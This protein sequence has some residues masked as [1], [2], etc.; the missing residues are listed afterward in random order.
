MLIKIEWSEVKTSATGKEYKKVSFKDA[1]GNIVDASA[2]SD[3]PF[4]AQIAPGA[5]IEA[6]VRKSAD[7]KYTNLV[8]ANQGSTGGNRGAGL[9]AMKTAQ[10]EK[11]MDKKASQIHAAQDRSAWMWAKNNAAT[12]IA[13]MPSALSGKSSIQVADMVVSLAT[14][15]YNGEPTE[16][17]TTPS[18]EEP[19]VDMSDIG[20]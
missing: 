8:M 3:A 5:E 17:F 1:S 14:R 20:L 2:W 11:A 16:P 15:I 12:L 9:T 4:Y 13:N 6:E 19:E 7:G 18:R 10:I